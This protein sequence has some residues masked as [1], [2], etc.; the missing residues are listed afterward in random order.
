MVLASSGSLAKRLPG[1]VSG[2]GCLG[3]NKPFTERVAGCEASPRET[4]YFSAASLWKNQAVPDMSVPMRGNTPPADPHRGCSLMSSFVRGASRTAN[5]PRD[6][7]NPG[8]ASTF[9]GSKAA[10]R[11]R[12]DPMPLAPEWPAEHPAMHSFEHSHVFCYDILPLN[13]QMA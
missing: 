5:G 9:R 12:V 13:I 6:S 8:M 10:A 3:E 1:P 11:D 2:T 7:G 4:L